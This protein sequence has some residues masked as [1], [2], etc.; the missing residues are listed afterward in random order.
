[1]TRRIAPTDTPMRQLHE[2]RTTLDINDHVLAVARM[3]SREQGRSL[4]SIVSGLARR[5][6]VELHA[7]S[8]ETGLRTFDV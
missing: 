1:M 7:T 3:L 6:L 8:T 2:V 5:G 4:G